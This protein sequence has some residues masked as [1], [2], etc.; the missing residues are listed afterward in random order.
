MGGS[1]TTVQAPPVDPAQQALE[2][3]QASLLQQQTSIL[4]TQQA[5]Y[6]A[7]APAL[8]AAMGYTPQYGANG[9]LTGLTLNAQGQQNLTNQQTQG[10]LDQLLLQQEQQALQGKLPVNPLVTQTL[11]Q[12]QTAMNQQMQNNLGPGWQASSPGQQ[13]QNL[14]NQS[15]AGIIQAANT[16][17]MSLDQQMALAGTAGG[18]QT[19]GATTGGLAGIYGMPTSLAQG[20]GQAAA[21]YGYAQQPYEFQSQ[22]T[23]QANM[24]NAQLAMQG[25]A[26][27]GNLVG[28]L[29][30]AAMTM[31][32]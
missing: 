13:A 5:N 19:A 14:F 24:A 12:Q 7:V 11:N 16:G 21:G 10:Q 23:L 27:I 20:Y 8:Y 32:A 18:I 31:F 30:G 9:Q 25:M 4:Q 6:A 22:Q 2:Q 29:G 17:Q 26:G 28:T 1:S 15:Q 3:Q